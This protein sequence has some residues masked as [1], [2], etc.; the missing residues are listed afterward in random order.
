MENLANNLINWHFIQRAGDKKFKYFDLGRTREGA[1]NLIFK[2]EWGGKKISQPYFYK[3]YKKELKERQEIQYKR[4][5]GLWAKYLPE[6]LATKIGPWL[7]KQI[8]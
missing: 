7:I 2:Q 8:G 6:F 3:F 5:S 4:L 1:G